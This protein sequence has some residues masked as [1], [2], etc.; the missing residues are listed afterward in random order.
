MLICISVSLVPWTADLILLAASAMA[1]RYAARRLD[2]AS[3][4]RLAAPCQKR[5]TVSDAVRQRCRPSTT[6]GQPGFDSSRPLCSG[7]RTLMAVQM[8]RC[9][10]S[11][12]ALPVAAMTLA[13]KALMAGYKYL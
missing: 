3:S 4:G 5:S 9:V 6:S 7:P 11:G 12:M 8:R 1:R 13:M 10:L 2:V